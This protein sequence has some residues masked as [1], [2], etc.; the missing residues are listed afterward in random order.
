M[1]S[2]RFDEFVACLQV[3]KAE[4]IS[5]W[6]DPI[7]GGSSASHRVVRKGRNIFSALKEKALIRYF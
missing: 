3:N 5:E 4:S 7:R 2:N 6:M 1:N